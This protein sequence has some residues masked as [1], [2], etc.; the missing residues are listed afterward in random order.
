M[1]SGFDSRNRFSS[2]GYQ[3]KTW[4]EMTKNSSVAFNVGVFV[5]SVVR[6]TKLHYSMFGK[7]DGELMPQPSEEV[8]K[9]ISGTFSE[10]LEKN[11]LNALIPL[12]Q[13]I[14][15]SQGEGYLD[16][17]GTLYGLL[18][19]SPKLLI[20][21]GLRALG[22]DEDPYKIYMMKYGFENVWNKIMA[23]EKFDVQYFSEVVSIYR[24]SNSVTLHYRKSN[25]KILNEQCDFLIWTPPMPEFINAVAEPTQEEMDLFNTL[26]PHF[27]VASLMK[28]RGVIRNRPIT[29]YQESLDEKIE[30]G[31]VADGSLEDAFNYCSK[32]C[33]STIEDYNK[34]SGTERHITVLQL[35]REAL[36]EERSNQ[37]AR[38]HYEKGF[39]ASNVDFLSTKT[40]EYFYKWAPDELSKGNHWKVFNIQGL[41]RTWYAGASV[42]F[43]TIK[44]VLEYNELLL[45]QILH[46]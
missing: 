23:K 31:V 16:E 8:L 1:N 24:N 43:E 2:A 10:F 11:N 38:D 15:T 6:Y 5:D 27:F 9:K 25:S 21:Y 42:C 45:K 18:W 14:H 30:G 44:S 41:Y 3:L 22:A 4:M 46:E 39:N 17:V 19:N 40:W 13:R 37:I 35:A 33:S 7:Y 26:T 12:F 29:Y 28:E 36:S 34:K 20:S 32:G